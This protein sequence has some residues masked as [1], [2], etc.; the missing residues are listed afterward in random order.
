MRRQWIAAVTAQAAGAG[1]NALISFGLILFLARSMGPEGFGGYIALLST[2]LLGLILIEGGWPTLLYR[3]QVATAPTTATSRL[4]AQA[5]AH[6]IGATL[7]LCAVAASVAYA[8]SSGAAGL[9]YA[10]LCM[11]AVATMNL[12]SGRLRG[13]GRFG[14]EAAW[15]AAGR[16]LSSL[17]IVLS[18]LLWGPEPWRVFL[19]WGAA[20]ALLLLAFGR[21]K[22]VPP[23]WCG[24]AAGYGIAL[25][26]IAYEALVAWLMRGDMALLGRLPLSANEL[27]GYAACSRFNEAAV[28]LFAPVG[29]VL[30]GQLQ[31]ASAA[32]FPRL[33][34]SVVACAAAAGLLA[35]GL[36]WI[37]G[38][39]VVP[40]LFGSDFAAA[41][42]L[43]GWVLLP[44]PLMLS[45]LALLPAVL[46]A[47][48]ERGLVLPLFASAAAMSLGITLGSHWYGVYGAAVGLAAA[49]ALLLLSSLSLL[50]RGRRKP[51]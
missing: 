40:K 18:V 19:G 24:I 34:A 23:Q 28:L 7:A 25:P 8:G 15:Q 46:A 51:P 33:V 50:R 42:H 2:A 45:N 1:F 29:N 36:G 11:G 4:T 37:A 13:D 27:S 12:V 6:I 47:G 38:P 48:Q 14:L 26:F 22:L 49:H 39:W 10:L 44:L 17:A 21:R 9:V 43:L 5:L 16:A 35:L 20:L 41:G 32:E 31:R 30:L 3:E